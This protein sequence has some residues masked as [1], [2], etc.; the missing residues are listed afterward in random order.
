MNLRPT[1]ISHIQRRRCILHSDAVEDSTTPVV[2][3]DPG[4][5]AGRRAF[6]CGTVRVPTNRIVAPRR[7]G[8]RAGRGPVRL[9]GSA[10]IYPC[11][12]AADVGV[13]ALDD[14]PGPEHECHSFDNG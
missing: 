13:P 1:T 4:P 6:H 10:D 7:E 11:T 5:V 2:Y 3:A 14:R 8:Y 12:T 9:K